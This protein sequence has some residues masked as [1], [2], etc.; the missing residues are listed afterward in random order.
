MHCCIVAGPRVVKSAHNR[1]L[2]PAGNAIADPIDRGRKRGIF[3]AAR[4]FT[5]RI[6]TAAMAAATSCRRHHGD[7][8][9]V[10][11]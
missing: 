6:A 2:R 1:K 4:A 10:F 5:D 8:S 11:G 9:T 3:A 7:C